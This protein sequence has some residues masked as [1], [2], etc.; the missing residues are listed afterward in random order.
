MRKIIRDKPKKDKLFLRRRIDGAYA[1]IIELK[2]LGRKFVF[3]IISSDEEKALDLARLHIWENKKE[4]PGWEKSAKV[5]L[6]EAL[7]G[8]HT[9]RVRRYYEVMPPSTP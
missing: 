5:V 7:M 6:K 4:I 8:K 2:L 3:F 1:F 9:E